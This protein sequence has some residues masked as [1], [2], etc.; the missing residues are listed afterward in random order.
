M[1][2]SKELD[3]DFIDPLLESY[4]VGGADA[5]EDIQGHRHVLRLCKKLVRESHVR[6]RR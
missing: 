3:L 1:Q 6:T 5:P 2:A 4:K